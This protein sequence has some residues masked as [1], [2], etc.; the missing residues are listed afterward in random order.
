MGKRITFNDNWTSNRLNIIGSLLAPSSPRESTLL[1]TL[2]PGAYTRRGQRI[3]DQ[4]GVALMEVYYVDLKDSKL[5]NISRRGKVGT[6][7][8]S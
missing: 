3:Q 8:N 6:G 5:A 2:Q 4:P 1:V 7:D